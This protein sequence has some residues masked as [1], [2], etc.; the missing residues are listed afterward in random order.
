MR[1]NSSAP[2]L[3]QIHLHGRRLG[4]AVGEVIP[5]RNPF[6]RIIADVIADGVQSPV[7]SHDTFVIIAL[8]HG[9]N[10][11]GTQNVD[12][13]G[14]HRFKCADQLAQ[15]FAYRRGESRLAPTHAGGRGPRPAHIRGW[16]IYHNNAVHMIGHDNP[17]IQLNVRVLFPLPGPTL[18]HNLSPIVQ[19]HMPMRQLAEYRQPAPCAQR[20]EIR[21]GLGIIVTL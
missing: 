18:G 8:P 21:A 6:G 4:V 2:R 11:R 16:R 14:R 20:H 17:F 1:P 13:F 12:A 5:V 10:G 19:S 3:M 7:I 15:R 9:R